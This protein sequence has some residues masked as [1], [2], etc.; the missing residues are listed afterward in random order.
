MRKHQP[1][2]PRVAFLVL[3]LALFAACGG[4]SSTIP[5]TKVPDTRENRDI[6]NAVENYR[7]AVERQDAGALLLMASKHYWEDAG[8]IGGSDDYGY[9]K[10][11]EVLTG[12]FQQGSELRYSVRYMRVRK[13]CPGSERKGCRAFVDVLVDAS[14]TIADARGEKIRRDKR[15]QNQFVLTWEG[16]RWRFLS[17]M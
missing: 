6:I 12:R 3:A 2:P 11:R 5:G 15:D 4:S 8:T 14:F 13:N 7:I 1:C 16:D 10:L 17:G 9:D